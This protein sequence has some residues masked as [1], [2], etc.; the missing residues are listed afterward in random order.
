DAAAIRV[1]DQGGHF[2]SF[3]DCSLQRRFNGRIIKSANSYFYALFRV[4]N[5]RNNRCYTVMGLDNQLH[6]ATFRTNARK[7]SEFIKRLRAGE[8]DLRNA[9]HKLF[10]AAIRRCISLV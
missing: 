3:E 10:S 5:R 9:P 6:F 8:Q 1:R 2:N 7:S 4:L